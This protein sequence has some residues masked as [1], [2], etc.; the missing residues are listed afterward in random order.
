MRATR[1]CA[2]VSDAVL[3]RVHAKVPEGASTTRFEK[4]FVRQIGSGVMSVETIIGLLK[5]TPVGPST[6]ACTHACMHTC[7]HAHMHACTHA[8]MHTCMHT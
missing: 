8:C 1:P 2:Q 7:M 5:E 6:H 4:S 3:R